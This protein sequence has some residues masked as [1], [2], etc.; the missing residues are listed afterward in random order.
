MCYKKHVEDLQDSFH[1]KEIFGFTV[2][3]YADIFHKLYNF[4]TH[5]GVSRKSLLSS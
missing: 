4:Y 1:D 2:K 3:W 5:N